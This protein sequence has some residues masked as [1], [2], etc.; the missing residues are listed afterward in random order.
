MQW[1]RECGGHCQCGYG[2]DK[3]GRAVS[4]V[5][6]VADNGKAVIVSGV[7]QGERMVPTFI[8]FLDRRLGVNS[9]WF[10]LP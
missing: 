6:I 1:I 3:R 4:L 7:D 8:A 10:K 9:P 2:K 5:K